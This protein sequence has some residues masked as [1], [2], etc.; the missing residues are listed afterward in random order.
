MSLD[1]TLRELERKYLS[2]PQDR[3]TGNDLQTFTGRIG[4]V[5]KQRYIGRFGSA[6]KSI[7]KNTFPYERSAIGFKYFRQGAS[8]TRSCNGFH[9]VSGIRIKIFSYNASVSIYLYQNLL[10]LLSGRPRYVKKI[11]HGIHFP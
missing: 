10:S 1:Q 4:D 11:A 9:Y 2:D 5:S 8:L 6:S 7:I 3:S